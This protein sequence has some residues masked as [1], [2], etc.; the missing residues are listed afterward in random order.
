MILRLGSLVGAGTPGEVVA[1]VSDEMTAVT[2][3]KGGR[4]ATALE[5]SPGLFR[6]GGTAVPR[7]WRTPAGPP[8]DLRFRL[9]RGCEVWH[10]G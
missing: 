5:E 2:V 8:G 4:R 10:P 6:Q 7:G 9:V 1:A 3:T